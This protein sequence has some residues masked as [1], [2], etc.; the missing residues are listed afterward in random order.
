[1]TFD[2]LDA[3]Y[4]NGFNDAELR[5]VS[6][7]YQN[8]TAELRLKMRGNPP[9][10]KTAN[11]YSEAVLQLAGLCYCSIEPPDSEHLW[12]PQRPVQVDGLPE[13]AAD[14][15]L[16]T[17]VQS[18]FGRDCFCCRLF[19]H[20]WNSFIHIAAAKAEFAWL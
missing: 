7:D 5:T 4:P 11:E 12:C 9:D 10:S 15:P 6:V 18:K 17:Y 2:E 20:D 3:R 19:V 16:L 1:M 13:D 14:F 8:R